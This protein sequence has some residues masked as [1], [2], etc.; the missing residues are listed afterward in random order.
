M[1]VP[2]LNAKVDFERMFPPDKLDKCGDV[3]GHRWRGSQ[4]LRLANY[5]K[6]LE[7]ILD[8]KERL[9][10]LDIGCGQ[11]DWLLKM[12]QSY[13]NFEYHGTDISENAI[14]WNKIKHP[15]IHYR[16][17]TLPDVGFPPE[18][19]DLI[20]AL[21]VVIYLE[22][23]Q[24]IL[25]LQNMAR[26][27]KPG[28]YLLVSGPLDGG[29]RYFA[30]EWIVN[31][32][33]KLLSIKRIEYNYT[34]IYTWLERYPLRVISIMQTLENV[35]FIPDLEF[36]IWA[37]SKKEYVM[38]TLLLIR[39][40]FIRDMAKITFIS[41]ISLLQ[42]ILGWEWLPR[43]CFGLAKRAMGDN[44]KSRIILLACK[45]LAKENA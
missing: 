28:G 18:K 16:Q 22:R 1:P 8:P 9:I 10:V 40:P 27:L 11:S 33:A 26:A 15:S 20:S 23:P 29:V 6:M 19:F 4:K 2:G 32:V 7:N 41:L 14:H 45:T 12:R 5:L 36:N 39:L 31:E 44:G 25:A 30:E 24:Q 42:R 34:R 17:E 37:A 3:W 38:G 43:L 35:I 13:N 21:E